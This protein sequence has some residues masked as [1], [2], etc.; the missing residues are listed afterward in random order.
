MCDMFGEPRRKRE[1]GRFRQDIL[2]FMLEALCGFVLAEPCT[3]RGKSLRQVLDR[4]AL[5]VEAA[6]PTFRASLRV[7]RRSSKEVI[8][9]GREAQ[10]TLAVVE[11]E[12]L[13]RIRA[14]FMPSVR[15][16]RGASRAI[17]P[18]D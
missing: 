11:S 18:T 7:R 3:G 8:V 2:T 9:V 4:D 13:G 15:F 5:G 17:P 16:A 1:L 6:V 14:A 10:P 12:H